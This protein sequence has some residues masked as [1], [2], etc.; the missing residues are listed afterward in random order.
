MIPTEVNSQHCSCLPAALT[1][2]KNPQTVL[3]MIFIIT[4]RRAFLISSPTFGTV[5][6][7]VWIW[8][9]GSF[10]EMLHGLQKRNAD[11]AVLCHPH[12]WN[13]NKINVTKW[14][15]K[16][17]IQ[18]FGFKWIVLKATIWCR[19]SS[20]VTFRC[21]TSQHTES[22]LQVRCIEEC[23][24]RLWALTTAF[25]LCWSPRFIFLPYPGPE[26]YSLTAASY[27]VAAVRSC[28]SYLLSFDRKCISE[29]ALPGVICS[30][31]DLSSYT[32]T[33]KHQSARRTF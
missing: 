19:I 23:I 16:M 29:N 26:P 32:V 17:Q 5:K 24:C 10:S 15:S 8:H 27:F 4:W 11:L 12:L 28:G 14:R 18:Y 7:P 22:Q 31:Q 1:D 30:Q 33:W 3:V 20:L 6:L 2:C 25:L 13:G 9:H 21:S